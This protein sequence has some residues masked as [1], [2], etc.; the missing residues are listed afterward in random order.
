MQ[1]SIVDQRCGS[2]FGRVSYFQPD[3]YQPISQLSVTS[4]KA[5]PGAKTDLILLALRGKKIGFD[6]ASVGAPLAEISSGIEL[7]SPPQG[8]HFN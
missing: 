6:K 1:C 2:C 3:P 4:R 5:V 7:F 8:I